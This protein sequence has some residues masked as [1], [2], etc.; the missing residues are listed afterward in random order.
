MQNG[1][2]VI[3]IWII[4]AFISNLEVAQ[5]YYTSILKDFEITF[6]I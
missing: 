3:F 1:R 2:N 5:Y 6:K 4:V